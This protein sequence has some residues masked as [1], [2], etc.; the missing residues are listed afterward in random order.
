MAAWSEILQEAREAVGFTGP[1]VPR[2]LEGIRAALRPDRLPDL[3]TEL[4]TLSEGSAFEA[5]LD[6]WWAQSL[7]DTATDANAKALAIDFADLA[8]ALR[9]KATGG[10]GTYTQAEVEDMLRGKAS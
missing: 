3:D 8:I 4:A 7:A 6:H 9:A 5:F 2:N 1:M 10:S